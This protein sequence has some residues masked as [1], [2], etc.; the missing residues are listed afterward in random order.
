MGAKANNAPAP[1]AGPGLAIDGR[2]ELDQIR[3]EHRYAD[4]V[5]AVLWRAQDACAPG[6]VC[7]VPQA[8]RASKFLFGVVVALVLIG[9]AFPYVAPWFY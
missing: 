4:G 1:A 7:A 2:Y 9:L 5:H 6:D 3:A 8:R